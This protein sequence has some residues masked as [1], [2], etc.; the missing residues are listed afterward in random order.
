MTR[1]I[2]VI[3]MLVGISGCT[4]TL[5]QNELTEQ[6]N[7]YLGKPLEERISFAGEPDTCAQLS[8]GGTSCQWLDK[9][10]NHYHRTFM[11]NHYRI[12]CGWKYVGEE[13]HFGVD[14]CTKTQQAYNSTPN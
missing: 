9:E 6:Y 2:I 13:G 12:G 5:T 11:Y 14:Q 7:Y 10:I 4:T 1:M 8:N 3:I